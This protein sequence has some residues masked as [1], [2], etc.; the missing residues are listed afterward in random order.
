MRAFG[1]RNN[2]NIYCVCEESDD[3]DKIK[4]FQ[5]N[6]LVLQTQYNISTMWQ[7]YSTRFYVLVYKRTHSLSLCNGTIV[8][9]LARIHLLLYYNDNDDDNAAAYRIASSDSYT[10]LIYLTYLFAISCV[11]LHIYLLI[12]LFYRINP[13]TIRWREQNLRHFHFCVIGC[14]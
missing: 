11:C 6:A 1:T 7:L 14:Q 2:G 13:S 3:D 5:S 10:T 12:M 9:E 8:L 4:Y